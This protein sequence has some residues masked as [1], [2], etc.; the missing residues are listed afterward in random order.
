MPYVTCCSWAT[1]PYQLPCTQATLPRQHMCTQATLPRQHMCT[2]GYPALPAPVYPGLPCPTSS[3]WSR[4][5]CP[6]SSR[7]SR[8]PCPVCSLTAWATLPCVLP[9]S[10]ATLPKEEVPS[11]GETLPDHGKLGVRCLSATPAPGGG[12]VPGPVILP[13]PTRQL[14]PRIPVTI[15]ASRVHQPLPRHAE[16]RQRYTGW[17]RNHH[18]AQAR[19]LAW[20]PSSCATTLPSLVSVLRQ[21]L[22][23]HYARAKEGMD[24]NRIAKGLGRL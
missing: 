3:R 19:S 6:D 24:N 16:H 12:G 15:P 1:L 10:L 21:E 4:L 22:T 2:L 17:I 9:D 5:P 20:V 14:Y 11:P 23:N 7:W 18:R 8:L 13:L